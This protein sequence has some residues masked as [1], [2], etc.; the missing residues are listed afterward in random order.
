MRQQSKKSKTKDKVTKEVEEVKQLPTISVKPIT[1]SQK[2]FL[3]AISQNDI[4]V[5]SGK[6]GS[7][8]THISVGIALQK[9]F[10]GEIKRI[11]ITRPAVYEG[12]G[13]GFLPGDIS[14]KMAPFLMP[15]YDELK[16]FISGDLLATMVGMSN[17]DESPQIEIVPLEFVR[18]RTFKNCLVGNT[19]IT[20][21]NGGTK[22]IKDI[23]IGDKVLSFDKNEGITS[24]KVVATQSRMPDALVEVVAGQGVRIKG[25]PEHKVFALTGQ[26]IQYTE[27]K[28]LK[29]GDYLLSNRSHINLD[30]ES[31]VTPEEAAFVGVVLCDGHIT[32]G[33]GTVAIQI[34]SKDEIYMR[35]L[36]TDYLVQIP[37]FG[38]TLKETLLSHRRAINFRIHNIKWIQTLIDKFNIPV[39]KKSSKIQIPEKIL[40]SSEIVK[41]SFISA[42]LDSE[43]SVST[44][45]ENLII[46]FASNSK[47]FVTELSNLLQIYG[48]KSSIWQRTRQYKINHEQQFGLSMHN[49]SAKN[50]I[51][52]IGFRLSRKQNKAS[53]SKTYN[54]HKASNPVAI[55]ANP[56]EIYHINKTIGYSIDR[57]KSILQSTFDKISHVLT[58]ENYQIGKNLELMY[59]KEVNPVSIIEPVYDFEVENTHNFFANKVLSSNCYILVDEAQNATFSQLRTLATRIGKG[60]KL[61]FNGDITQCDLPDKTGFPTFMDKLKDVPGVGVVEMDDAD[62][63]R[64]PIIEKVIKALD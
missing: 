26:T 34:N 41:K 32:R 40:N 49:S 30:S 61:I 8:R 48:I 36:I 14:S 24:N 64:H 29:K 58:N 31:N 53:I 45:G 15:I 11:I 51:Q 60:S 25:T 1:Y 57:F 55:I 62:I 7:G 9:L 59:I 19:I 35:K 47:R 27:L 54:Q 38:L 5:C 21:E 17:Y 28:N 6:A 22:F 10:H 56:K 43:G 18:G 39:G 33:R 37:E 50:Y 42:C 46:H 16:E 12:R 2:R 23:K 52:N 44:S 3:Y 20:L 13:Q 63:V 4:T